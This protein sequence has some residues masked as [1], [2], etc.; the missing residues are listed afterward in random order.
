MYNVAARDQRAGMD[1][2]LIGTMTP[3]SA[4]S[5]LDL[6]EDHFP[7]PH[8]KRQ[9][10]ELMILLDRI[11]TRLRSDVESTKRKALQPKVPKDHG[12]PKGGRAVRR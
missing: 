9:T 7:T 12:A 10:F 1:A 2:V 6:Y 11:V 8:A 5:V 4:K 3:E